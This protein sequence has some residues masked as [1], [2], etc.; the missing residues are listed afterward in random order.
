[1]FTSGF[2]NLVN[3]FVQLKDSLKRSTQG[4][5]TRDV[6]SAMKFNV[7]AKNDNAVAVY[8]GA[9]CDTNKYLKFE[10]TV[11]MAYCQLSQWPSKRVYLNS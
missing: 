5:L 2:E 9:S 6:I 10:F 7:A 1:M 8:L 3:C 11:N 4:T